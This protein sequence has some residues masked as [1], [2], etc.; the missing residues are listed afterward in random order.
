M[1][2]HMHII[3]HTHIYIYT[4]FTIRPVNQLSPNNF[5]NVHWGST[6]LFTM[7]QA[8]GFSIHYEQPMLTWSL[9]VGFAQLGEIFSRKPWS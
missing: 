3:T 4:V 9:L 7:C 6:F 8:F 2:D 1:Y 5:A